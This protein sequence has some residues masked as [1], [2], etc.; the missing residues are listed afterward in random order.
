MTDWR[1]IAV[2]L[3]LVEAPGFFFSESD[4]G[5]L[6]SWIARDHRIH[7]SLGNDAKECS[8]WTLRQSGNRTIMSDIMPVDMALIRLELSRE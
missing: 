1:Q 5:Q 8:W 7:V 2:Q 6:L 4:D 3:K